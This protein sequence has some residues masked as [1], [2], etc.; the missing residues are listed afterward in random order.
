MFSRVYI[1]GMDY[2]RIKNEKKNTN[3]DLSVGEG[4]LG[5]CMIPYVLQL[6]FG[7]NMDG[8]EGKIEKHI[9]IND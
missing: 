7:P 1:A 5:R 8:T 2:G 3:N 9:I 6:L 4:K